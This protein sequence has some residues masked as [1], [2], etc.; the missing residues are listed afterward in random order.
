MFNLKNCL[1]KKGQISLFQICILVFGIVAF[2]YLIGG[3]FGSPDV[4]G[5]ISSPQQEFNS[6]D[7]AKKFS[8][9]DKSASLTRDEITYLMKNPSQLP[10]IKSNDFRWDKLDTSKVVSEE[11]IGYIPKDAFSGGISG[12]MVEISALGIS[13]TGEWSSSDYV[14]SS[15]DSFPVS[16]TSRSIITAVS[17]ADVANS[18]LISGTSQPIGSFRFSGSVGD[19][20]AD[21]RVTDISFAI[22]SVGNVTVSNVKLGADGT[23][24]QMDCSVLGSTI[25][26]AGLDPQYGSFEDRPRVLTLYGDI[27]IPASSINPSLQITINQAGSTVSAGSLTWTDGY[28]SFTWVQLGSP[29]S[30]GTRY[31]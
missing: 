7:I 18:A 9:P 21:L 4:G 27:V 3:V 8:D 10:D 23:S 13:G 11:N 25:T 22:A 16:Q 28:T 12:E 29:V 19:G 30:R 24:D 31:E 5:V 15:T 6:D 2:T 26:C 14:S 17:N 20:Q 1:S